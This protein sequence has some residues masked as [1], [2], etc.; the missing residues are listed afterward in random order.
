MLVKWNIPDDNEMWMYYKENHLAKITYEHED[1]S[2]ESFW[3]WIEKIEGDNV[4]GI[5][6]SKLITFKKNNLDLQIGDI[7]RFNKI[8]IKE[9]SSRNYTKEEIL[10]SIENSKSNPITDYFGS[11]NVKFINYK[12]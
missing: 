9:L 5:I 2:R 1:G 8:C 10:F 12:N 11:L 4:S 6:Y 3:I 7:V